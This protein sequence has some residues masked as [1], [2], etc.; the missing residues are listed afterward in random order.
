MHFFEKYKF[1]PYISVGSTCSQSMGTYIPDRK[2][3][4]MP[5]L[6]TCT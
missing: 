5:I 6:P 1:Q 4:P 2:L 3:M